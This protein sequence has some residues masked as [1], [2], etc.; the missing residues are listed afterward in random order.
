MYMIYVLR[1]LSVTTRY[2]FTL[3]SL[4][5]TRVKSQVKTKKNTGV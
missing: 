2:N 3:F 4:L 1:A 5:N